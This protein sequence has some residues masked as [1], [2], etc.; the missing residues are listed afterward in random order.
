MADY[1]LLKSHSIFMFTNNSRMQNSTA[2]TPQKLPP[3]S[4]QAHQRLLT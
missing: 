4:P 2:L 1:L 3:T